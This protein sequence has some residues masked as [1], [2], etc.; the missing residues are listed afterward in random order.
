MC[1]PKWRSAN[2]STIAA[3]R[4]GKAMRMRMAVT[5]MFQVKMGSRNIVIPGARR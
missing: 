5:S 2:S 1:V 4:M 3:V